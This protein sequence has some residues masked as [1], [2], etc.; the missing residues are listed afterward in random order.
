[1]RKPSPFDF[2]SRFLMVMKRAEKK[3]RI[4]NLADPFPSYEDILEEGGKAE[5]EG[6]KI[7]HP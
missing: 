3:W 7:N 5:R 1:M 6:N 4:Q 2:C